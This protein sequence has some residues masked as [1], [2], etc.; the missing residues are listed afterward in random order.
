MLAG[1]HVI[2]LSWFIAWGVWN[3][4]GGASVSAVVIVATGLIGR[5][6]PGDA[7]LAAA[8]GVGADPMRCWLLDFERLR[9]PARPVDARSAPQCGDCQK[10]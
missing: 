5:G 3:E 4:K 6:V 10:S 2:L 7:G 9:G 8:T 1:G